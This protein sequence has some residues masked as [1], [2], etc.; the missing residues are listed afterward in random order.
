MKRIW[1]ISAVLALTTASAMAPAMAEEFPPV[2]DATVVKECSACH[3]VFPPQMLPARSWKALL[4]KLGSHFGEDATVADPDRHAIVD[5]LT[6]HAA[7]GS[8]TNG[9]GKYLRGIAA[10]TTPLR[11]TATPYWLRRHDEVSPARFK[12]PQVKSAANCAACHKGAAQ[13]FFSEAEEEE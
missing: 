1:L 12:S 5:Y 4:G 2:K 10:N 9:G 6:A 13:G 11:I 8:A 7:D 3:I